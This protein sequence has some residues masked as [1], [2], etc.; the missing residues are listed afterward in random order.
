M[1]HRPRS[2]TTGRKWHNA[3]ENRP[4]ECSGLPRVRDAF[5]ILELCEWPF[6]VELLMVMTT[7]QRAYSCLKTLLT[8]QLPV[9]A[10]SR[11]AIQ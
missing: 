8:D 3:A 9:E 1:H 2:A 4:N 5:H 7:R 10:R 11:E 6:F